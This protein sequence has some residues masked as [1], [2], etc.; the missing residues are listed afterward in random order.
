MASRPTSTADG[1]GVLGPDGGRDRDRRFG[2]PARS[3]PSAAA[4]R[5]GPRPA[6]S[7]S[8]RSSPP[9][10]RRGRTPPP[11]GPAACELE[12][13]EE[14]LDL[15]GV[16]GLD[17]ERGRPGR[18][19]SRRPACSSITTTLM[20][21]LVLVGRQV[22]PQLR[23]L[24]V[25]VLVDAV[26]VAVGVDQLG[27]RLLPHPGHA[28]QVVG[29]VAPERG[30]LHV[31]VRRDPGPLLDPG[32]V[33]EGVVADAPLV[34]DDLDVG[35]ADQ[36]VAVA[37]AGDDQDLDP[38]GRGPLGQGGQDVVGLDPACSTCRIRRAS[39]TSRTRP[40]CWRRMSGA[41]DRLAL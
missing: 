5:S 4:A 23:G 24:V 38:V 33:V 8:A 26:D 10:P 16:V 32:L 15:L 9:S 7:R 22:L 35:V 3:A 29:V 28:G 39:S 21:D 19:R 20:P 40:I 27:R 30:V 18:G 17:A 37:V 6:T 2:Q 1:S 25:D 14:L 41:A 11:G 34:V 31:L 12:E 13:V 36:L